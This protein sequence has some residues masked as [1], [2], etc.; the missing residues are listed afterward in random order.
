MILF[1]HSWRFK[2]VSEAAI[3]V[4]AAVKMVSEAAIFNFAKARSVST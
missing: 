4:S 2:T 3:S 1:V